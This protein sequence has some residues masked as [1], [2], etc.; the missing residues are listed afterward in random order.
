MIGDVVH[1]LRYLR[2]SPAS[3]A[4]AVVTLALTLGTTTTI[5]AIVDAVL[6]TPPPFESP[7]ALVTVGETPIA[8]PLGTPRVGSYQT[9]EAWRAPAGSLA[10]LAGFDPTNVT[11]TGLGSAERLTAT[12]V[13]PG[14]LS[15]LG[16]APARGRTF[17]PADVGQPVAIISHSFWQRT[18]A[19]DPARDQAVPLEE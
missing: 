8:G 6:L 15:L 5:F 7:D 19:A 3:A 14:F 18:F 12:D 17:V 13:A 4:A 9:F 11:L 2:R 16:V 10:T 1:L